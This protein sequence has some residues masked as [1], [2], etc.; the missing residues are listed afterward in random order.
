MSA[1]SESRILAAQ[2]IRGSLGYVRQSSKE[3]K[4]GTNADGERDEIPK[5]YALH[6]NQEYLGTDSTVGGM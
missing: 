3:T 1:N 2:A 5:T 4:Y 6:L